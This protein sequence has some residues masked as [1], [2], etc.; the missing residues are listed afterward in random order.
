MDQ[1]KLK[2]MNARITELCAQINVTLD[3]R[4]R[5]HPSSTNWH[6]YHTAAE[7]IYEDVSAICNDFCRETNNV[8]A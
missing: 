1:S 4:D 2:E 8:G 7:V 3:K 5:Y 6:K